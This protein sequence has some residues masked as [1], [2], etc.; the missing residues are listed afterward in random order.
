MAF[1]LTSV[2]EGV[3][4][5]GAC[6]EQIEYLRLDQLVSDANNFY[7]LSK[8]DDLAANIQLC[9]LQQPIRV[10]RCAD[11]SECYTIVS[12]HRRRAAI[13]LLAADE[14]ERWAEVPCIVEQDEASPALQQLRLIYANANTR[15]MLPAEISEQAVQVEKLLYQLK[16]EGYSFPGRMRDHVAQ[17]VNVSKSKLSR[18]KVIRDN[19]SYIWQPMFKAGRLD[20][21]PAY[22]LA[23]MPL[24]WQENIYA[25]HCTTPGLLSEPMLETIKQRFS[26]ID[27]AECKQNSIGI[28]VNCTEMRLKSC[29][30][31]Y[32][33]PCHTRCC[34]ECP[35][36]RNCG[37][38]CIHAA[39]KKRALKE[40]ASAEKAEKLEAE[41]PD[42]E[43][44]SAL[45]QRFGL[46]REL[47]YKDFDACKKAMGIYYFPFDDAKAMQ[48]ECG[49][50]K[51]SPQTKLP[52]G[53]SCYLPEIKRLIDLAD[54]FGCSLD[55][56]LCR[57][58][59]KEMARQEQPV[60]TVGTMWHP[61]SEEPPMDVDLVWADCYGHADVGK[62]WGN[63]KISVSCTVEYDE[64]R[65]WAYLPKEEK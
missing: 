63:Q 61:I 53:Y 43:Q 12:G 34:Y 49:E 4:E 26:E 5:V 11:G 1:D 7:Q 10:R 56:L 30:D 54:L 21:T 46:A 18:L 6:R 44:I 58:D 65:W 52:F 41:K 45:W 17:A 36:L 9:G 38:S 14:P 64:A 16:E 51:I 62:Y 2:L 33:D 27:K 25:I 22:C 35:N 55:W 24:V 59:V 3:P 57:T 23:Q 13:E 8:I 47:A 50:G 29:V 60:P 31:R 42:V 48:L 15:V 20:E 37:K 39:D 40:N 32:S 28:C 19:L